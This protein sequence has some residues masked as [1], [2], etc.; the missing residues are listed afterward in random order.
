MLNS[1]I[2]ITCLITRSYNKNYFFRYVILIKLVKTCNNLIKI[3]KKIVFFQKILLFCILIIYQASNNLLIFIYMDTLSILNDNFVYSLVGENIVGYIISAVI[4]IIFITI[5]ALATILAELKIS[6]WM[7]RRVG[8]W[9]NTYHGIGQPL[10]EVIKLLQKEDT[11]PS[12]ADKILFNIAP[13]LVFMGTLMA[14]AALPFAPRFIPSELN[15]GLYYVFAVSA[16]CVVGIIIGG[17]ASHNKYSLLGGL[18]SA[19]QMVSYEIPISIVLL[20]MAVLTGSL[21]MREIVQSQNGWFWNWNIFGGAE[22][23]LMKLAVMPFTVGLF[24]IYFTASLAETNRVPFDLPEGESEI[25]AGY[26]TEYSGMKYAMFYLAEYANMFVVAALITVMFL[27]GWNSPF[28]A[29]LSDAHPDIY[30]PF[31]FIIKVA[32]IIFLQI[33]IRWTLPRLRIDQV[34]HVT[35]KVLVPCGL[36]CLLV[37]AFYTMMI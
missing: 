17:W 21:E 31:W 37:V 19:A 7:Q 22:G 26:S 8:P 3:N 6:A 13:F 12:R 27:G 29:N 34:M 20:S 15:V 9:R 5:Y 30:Q 28:G 18:R 2:C 24:L 4:I 14:F 10:L 23:G 35:W 33:V 36:V 11:T 16:F 32:V 1:V 25:V